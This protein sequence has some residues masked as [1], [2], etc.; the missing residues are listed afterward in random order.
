MPPSPV[1]GTSAAHLLGVVLIAYVTRVYLQAPVGVV[2]GSLLLMLGLIGSY[3]LTCQDLLTD[4]YC[5][6]LLPYEQRSG[7][8]ATI[9]S[10]NSLRFT[11]LCD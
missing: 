8:A 6:C 2:V 10:R 3:S 4:P 11:A 7:R 1:G 5:L 9:A